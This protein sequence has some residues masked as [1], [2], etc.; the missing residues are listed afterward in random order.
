MSWD[1]AREEKHPCPCGKGT[2]SEFFTSNDWMQTREWWAMNCPECQKN[3]RLYEFTYYRDAMAETGRRWVQK[4]V[5]DRAQSMVNEAAA[6]TA[7]AT[8]DAKSRY[9]DRL[10]ESCAGLTKKAVWERIH[11]ELPHFSSLGTFYTHTK[12]KG[13]KEYLAELFWPDRIPHALRL[14]GVQDD[15]LL[16]RLTE[17]TRLEERAESLFF[18]R[19]K[20]ESN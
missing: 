12:E 7:S 1:D 4:P 6:L 3:Y 16:S 8:R 20:S 11:G 5:F 18:G 9:L 15:E 13:A 10:V 17:A 14:A 19:S 2:Y